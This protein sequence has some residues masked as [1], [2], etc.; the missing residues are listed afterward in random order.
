MVGNEKILPTLP[1][2]DYNFSK[3]GLELRERFIQIK[4][5][6]SIRQLVC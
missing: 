2:F 3:S 1:D 6:K 5:T 4:H